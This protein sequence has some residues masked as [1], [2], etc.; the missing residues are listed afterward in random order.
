M[1]D[2]YHFDYSVNYLQDQLNPSRTLSF[3]KIWTNKCI[4]YHVRV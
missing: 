4:S 3:S 2:G 1:F